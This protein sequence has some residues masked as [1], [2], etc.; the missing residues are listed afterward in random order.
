MF[1]IDFTIEALDDLRSL[2]K[3]DHQIIISAIES[4]LS[5]QADVE[6][7]NRKRLRPNP[8]AEWEVRAGDYRI[9]YDL[10]TE[11]SVVRIKAVGRKVGG[12]LFVHGEEYE[13]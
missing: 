9:F 2:R 1:T 6:T 4:Q 7:R 3:F 13:L 12:K 5:D 11:N 8:L 10:D